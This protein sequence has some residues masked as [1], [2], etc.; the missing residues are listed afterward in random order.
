[1]LNTTNARSFNTSL[2]RAL[3]NVGVEVKVRVINS[4]KFP[5]CYVA[6]Y[7]EKP[8]PNEFRL[9]LFDATHPDRSGLLNVDD[10]SYGNI[11]TGYCTVKVWQWEK[12]F[13]ENI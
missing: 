13:A 9:K 3:N 6:I 4:Y 5:N 8:L 2:K 11:Q 7:S 10:V 12:M 1:M